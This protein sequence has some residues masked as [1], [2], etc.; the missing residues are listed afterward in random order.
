MAQSIHETEASAGPMHSVPVLGREFWG[1]W[2]PDS[3]PRSGAIDSVERGTV[4]R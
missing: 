4:N 2:N 1:L 3:G